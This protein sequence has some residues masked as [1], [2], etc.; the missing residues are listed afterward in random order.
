MVMVMVIMIMMMTIKAD[1]FT[2][3]QQGNLKSS[4]QVPSFVIELQIR[5]NFTIPIVLLFFFLLFWQLFIFTQ[6]RSVL[7]IFHLLSVKLTSEETLP[8]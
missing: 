3:L 5:C 1:M 7:T 8:G 2:M 4:Q 6:S